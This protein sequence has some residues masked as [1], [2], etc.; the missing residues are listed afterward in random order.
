MPQTEKYTEKERPEGTNGLFYGWETL[1][2][3][4][5]KVNNKVPE[6]L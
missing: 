1:T 3:A 6:Y 5:N 2:H 4:A